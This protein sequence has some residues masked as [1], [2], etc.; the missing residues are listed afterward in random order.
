VAPQLPQEGGNRKQI[1]NKNKAA[2]TK[3]L[4]SHLGLNLNARGDSEPA[5]EKVKR[6]NEV[7]PKAKS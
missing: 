3:Q 5:T 7:H 2:A 4:G 6:E 1:K